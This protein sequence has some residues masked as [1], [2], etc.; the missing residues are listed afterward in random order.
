MRP[1]PIH[2]FAFLSL[3]FSSLLLHVSAQ[4][5][6]APAN[7]SS[8]TTQTPTH[9]ANLTTF[10]ATS[11]YTTTSVSFSG[12]QSIP[13]TTVVPTI[14]N[15]TSTLPIPT[16]STTTSP[17]PTPTPIMLATEITPAFGVLGAILILT[18]LPSAFWGHKNRWCAVSF[19][20]HIQSLILGPSGPPSSSSDF[21]PCPSFAS[22]SSSSLASSQQ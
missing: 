16:T 4:S 15:V 20:S 18:G 22:F 14:Y 11:S 19:T 10:L 6:S 1:P 2:V 17:T 8:S 21:I 7:S 3:L 13:I 5:S 12:S 9:S